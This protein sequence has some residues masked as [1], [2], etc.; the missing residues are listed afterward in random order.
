M[1]VDN[2]A[3]ITS[4]GTGKPA[5]GSYI[6]DKIHVSYQRVVERHRQLKFMLSWVP[7]HKGIP[8]N[9][10][11]DEEAK[12]GAQGAHNNTS[13]Q[14]PFLAKGLLQ[15]KAAI[16]PAYREDIKRQVIA[17]FT[18]SPR[19]QRAVCI[20]STMPSARFC[21]MIA[22]LLRHHAS[23]LI[24]LRTWH[25]PLK[26]YLHQF[27]CAESPLCEGCKQANKMVEHYLQECPAYEEQCTSSKGQF[28][29]NLNPLRKSYQ[30]RKCCLICSNTS[31]ACSDSRNNL[32]TYPM[33]TLT[34]AKS[35][36]P[37]ASFQLLPIFVPFSPQALPLHD[38]VIVF[39]PSFSFCLFLFLFYTF[40][41][42]QT[43]LLILHYT[44]TLYPIFT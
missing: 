1:G 10:Q 20:D 42:L 29:E 28:T 13:N 33:Q 32:A 43:L 27:K 3:A 40:P 38:S 22:K 8:G 16:W 12:K 30:T 39:P 31:Q 2:Q 9:K 36:S 18:G 5:L 44:A 14:I 7:G 25:I 17:N 23:L 37:K 26:Q 21:R 11:A 35:P 4:T 34:M 19:Y 6:V 24:Q 15:S 41:T